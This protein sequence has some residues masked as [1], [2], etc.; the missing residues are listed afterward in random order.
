MKKLIIPII[1]LAVC[2]TAS[3]ISVISYATSRAERK[4]QKNSG[5][6]SSQIVAVGTFDEIET[7]AVNI[8]LSIGTASTEGTLSG[9]PD[10][11]AKV[12]VEND[13]GKLKV[14]YDN[15]G[16]KSNLNLAT[17]TVSAATVKDIEASLASNVTVDGFIVSDDK[18]ELN[19]ETAA[20]IS[21]DNIQAPSLDIDAETASKITVKRATLTSLKCE[22]E[23]AS[24]ISVAGTCDTMTLSAQTAG[25]ISA[26]HM[27]AASTTAEA[28]TGGSV[29]CP[30][31]N[32]SIRKNTGGSVS[33]N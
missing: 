24:H 27:K 32:I 20:K 19:A 14:V 6:P 17:L 2:I 7:E 3:A 8:R 25:K 10:V 13:N 12:R 9:D 23:T 21:V 28:Y 18:V 11:V 26:S 16:R 30:Q 29:R 33:G 4:E 31:E 15:P 1:C 5:A 22:A